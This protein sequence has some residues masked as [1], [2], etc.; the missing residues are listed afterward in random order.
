M[1][2]TI[3]QD[4]AQMNRENPDPNAEPGLVN[5]TT[6]YLNPGRVGA[7]N[8]NIMKFHA[9]I[10]EADLPFYYAS[11]NLVSGGNGPTFTIAG[12]A[13]NWAGFAEPDPGMEAAMMEMYGEEEALEIFSAFGG[14]YRYT[15]TTIARHRPDLSAGG[16]M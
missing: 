6:F 12:F 4:N 2:T 8:E 10:E 13:A 15:V 9:A 14:S 5:V 7:F 16:G 3:T 1:S 11:S